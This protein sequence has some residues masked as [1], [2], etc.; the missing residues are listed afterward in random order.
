VCCDG[1]CSGQCESC[2]ELD[3]LGLCVAIRGEPRSERPACPAAPADEPCLATECDGETR[4]ECRLLAGADVVCSEESCVDGFA[5]R[6]ARCDGDGSC[7]TSTPEDCAP[8]VCGGSVCGTNCG[9]DADC[10]GGFRCEAP[11][12]VAGATCSDD[13][14]ELIGVDGERTSCSPYRCAIDR[15]RIGCDTTAHCAPGFACN[16]ENQQCETAHTQEAADDGG[17]G[18]RTAG[19]SGGFSAL[20]AA[21]SAAWLLFCLRRRRHGPVRRRARRETPARA[22]SSIPSAGIGEPVR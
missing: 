15:C 19:K 12:C 6:E 7:A 16:P 13:E 14:L 2:G 5:T 18:C 20:F 10:A 8:Y 11:R 4:G 3:A 1:A 21:A 9:S 17:C 22:T